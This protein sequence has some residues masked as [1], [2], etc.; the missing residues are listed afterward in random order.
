M[1]CSLSILFV[2]VSASLSCDLSAFIINQETAGHGLVITESGEWQLTEDISIDDSIIIVSP[3]VTLNLSGFS[4]YGAKQGAYSGIVVHG[5]NTI[6]KNGKLEHFGAAALAITDTEKISVANLSI[7][8]SSVGV[9]IM[10]T[11]S[12]QVDQ[13]TISDIENNALLLDNVGFVFVQASSINEVGGN[14]IMVQHGSYAVHIQKTYIDACVESGVLIDADSAQ[15][16]WVCIRQCM[17]DGIVIQGNNIQCDYVSS[18]QNGGSGFVLTG[19]GHILRGCNAGYNGC[20]GICLG[21]ES[22]SVSIIGGHYAL[23][24]MVGICNNGSVR[25]NSAY[26]RVYDN[27]QL[28]LYRIVNNNA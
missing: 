7:C 13:V 17:G 1:K 28:D 23:N 6:I 9:S 12:V 14:G 19:F 26:A 3:G 5:E 21:P 20:N 25:N 22:D 16:S 10:R 11:S 18:L 8:N 27:K 2:S 4:I 15:L 24:Q